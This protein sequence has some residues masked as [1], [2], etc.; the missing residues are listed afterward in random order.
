M[1]V[2]CCNCYVTSRTTHHKLSSQMVSYTFQS[3][4]RHEW[5]DSHITYRLSCHVVMSRPTG[6]GVGGGGAAAAHKAG[7]SSLG[8]ATGHRPTRTISKYYICRA[9]GNSRSSSTL[10]SIYFP[11]SQKVYLAKLF[12][13]LLITVGGTGNK[14]ENI[15]F[16]RTLIG[17]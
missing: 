13:P 17:Y 6:W 7:C 9:D 2:R 15:K 5:L 16:D 14:V 11:K 12:E 8:H 1:Q 3:V 4:C 10:Y